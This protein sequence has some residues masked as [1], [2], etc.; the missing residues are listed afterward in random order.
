MRV[1][2]KRTRS[3]KQDTKNSSIINKKQ[4]RECECSIKLID[5]SH[6]IFSGQ[7]GRFPVMSSKGNKHIMVAHDHGFNAIIA[8]A[9]KT[10]SSR[11][12]IENTQ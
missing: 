8:R 3:T 5:L 4:V 9:L 2:F 6:K 12:Q 1:D 7:N 10:K 11:E